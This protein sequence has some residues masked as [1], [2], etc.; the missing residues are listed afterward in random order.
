MNPELRTIYFNLV[1]GWNS[2]NWDVI[3]RA[4]GRLATYIMMEEKK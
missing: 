3:D 2:R 4:V 1:G